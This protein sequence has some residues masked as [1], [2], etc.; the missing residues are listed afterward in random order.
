MKSLGQ[1]IVAEFYECDSAV[2]ND[3][4]KIEEIMCGAARAA[5]ATIVTQTFHTFSPHG[6][7]GAVIIAESHLA[8]H[9]WPEYG[10]AAVDLFTCGDTVV[11]E[12]A[13]RH[14]KAGLGSLR[15]ST[16]EM[17][18]GQLEVVGELHHKPAYLKQAS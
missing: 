14:L 5:G 7:S 18:R 8:I 9:T 1:Q 13:Y 2:L 17:K 15:A 11:P 10:Y 12:A 3:P 6:V 4:R 16:M